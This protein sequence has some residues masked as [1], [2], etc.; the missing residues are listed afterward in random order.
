MSTI[1]KP[2]W[3]RFTAARY[4]PNFDLLSANSGESVELAG[5]KHDRLLITFIPGVWAPWCRRF[6]RELDRQT[7]QLSSE[8]VKCVAIIAQN[9]E[10]LANYVKENKLRIEVL[11]DTHGVIGKRYGVFDDNITEPMRISRPAI[12]ILNRENRLLFTF[13]GKHLMDRP[14]MEELYS[15]ATEIFPEDRISIFERIF[16]LFRRPNYANT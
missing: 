14:D 4:A 2:R 6:L 9:H 8:G 1:D 5:L 12:F 15:K 13:L 3:K 10:Q 7:Q 11:A 16:A